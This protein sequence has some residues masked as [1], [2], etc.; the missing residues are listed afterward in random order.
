MDEKKLRIIFKDVIDYL[1][2]LQTPTEQAVYNYLLRWSYFETGKNIVQKGIRTIAKEV[3]MPAKGKLSKTKGLS[4]STVVDAT[5]CLQKKKHIEIHKI[6]LKGIV[7][8]VKLPEEIEEC[9]KIKQKRIRSSDDTNYYTDPKKRKEIF[10]RDKYKCHYCGQTVTVEN[11]TLDHLIPRSKD[12]D[13]S[14]ENLVVSC[15]ECN[16]IKS[17]KTIEEVAPKLLER[18]KSKSNK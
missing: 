14:K 7:Y 10:E 12:G 2:P 15:F 16:S 8:L 3:S 13:D 18:L 6:E 5:R 9:V 1:S 17:G 4:Y 11:A